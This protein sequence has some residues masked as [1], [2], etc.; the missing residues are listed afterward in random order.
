MKASPKPPHHSRK[1]L[2]ERAFPSVLEIDVV[3]L[4][5]TFFGD[6]HY[7][8]DGAAA[9][10]RGSRSSSIR[11]SPGDGAPA[12][13]TASR[14]ALAARRVPRH[15]HPLMAT[16][17]LPWFPLSLMNAKSRWGSHISLTLLGRYPPTPP[18]KLLPM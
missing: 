5:K 1:F 15:T 13:L 4:E 11:L 6:N 2:H 7:L 16:A 14:I 12:T 9:C 18:T 8:G 3:R 10:Q 17:V